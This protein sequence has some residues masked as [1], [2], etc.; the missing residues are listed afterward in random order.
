MPEAGPISR[1]KLEEPRWWIEPMLE[2]SRAWIERR[3]EPLERFSDLLLGLGVLMA[4]TQNDTTSALAALLWLVLRLVISPGSRNFNWVLI[5]ILLLNLRGVVLHEG[6]KPFSH[7]EYIV[8][9]AALVAGV[10]RTLRHWQASLVA[11]AAAGVIGFIFNLTPLVTSLQAIWSGQAA[12]PGY[13]GQT[14]GGQYFRVGALSVNQTAFLCGLTLCQSA[15]VAIRSRGRLRTLMTLAALTSALAAFATGSRLAV[16]LPPLLVGTALALTRRSPVW[17]P[18]RITLVI[19]AA[20][21]ALVLVV[22][23][24]SG[25]GSW[26]LQMFGE[27]K[28]TGDDGRIAVLACYLGLPFLE[29][30][31]WFFGAGYGAARVR[32]C[33]EDVGITVSH[34]HNFIVQIIAD[35][36][37][38]SA[39]AVTVTAVLVFGRLKRLLPASTGA[40]ATDH[41]AHVIAPALLASCLFLLIFNSFEL[42]TMKVTMLIA[43][44]GFLPACG[45][46]VQPPS[47][48][49]AE[50]LEPVPPT[51]A[52]HP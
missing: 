45:F 47:D 21:L 14:W 39:A 11:I 37:L 15:I 26:L 23:H 29:P 24:Q 10:G 28:S 3:R 35:S 22:A 18:R 31:F 6:T 1:S 12:L 19:G 30:G 16:L 50:P 17:R 51:G 44:F 34:A 42:T 5:L 8:L 9:I 2:R 25:L 46:W 38:I 20:A 32:F 48:A 41:Q 13:L 36:G 27:R 43:L 7:I 40:G 4:W 33:D 52:T 49:G